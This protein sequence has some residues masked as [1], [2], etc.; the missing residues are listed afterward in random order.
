MMEAVRDISD[1]VLL[2]VCLYNI[3]LFMATVPALMYTSTEQSSSEGNI[4]SAG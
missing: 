2:T 4:C 1:P 3:L